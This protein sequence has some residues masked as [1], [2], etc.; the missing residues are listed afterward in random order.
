MKLEYKVDKVSL[1]IV[2]VPSDYRECSVCGHWKPFSEFCNQQGVMTRT[3]CSDCYNMPLEDMRA[4][5][6]QTSDFIRAHRVDIYNISERVTTGSQLM[7][8]RAFLEQITEQ[9][10][11]IGD[12]ELVHAV[13]DTYDPDGYSCKEPLNNLS[14]NTKRTK[15]ELDVPTDIVQVTLC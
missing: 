9:L 7:T 15:I 11:D 8:K 4:L 1:T 13:Y 5:S 6:K 12:N 3:N 2:K 10:K 14:V